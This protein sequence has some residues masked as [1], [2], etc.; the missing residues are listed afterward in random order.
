M[1]ELRCPHKK[2]AELH[3]DL[4]QVKCNSSRCG[5]RP[6]VV[7]I[8]VFDKGDG[9]LVKTNMFKDPVRRSGP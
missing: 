1:E 7:V 9:R 5:V 3:R 4:I 2:F 8:H 6:G